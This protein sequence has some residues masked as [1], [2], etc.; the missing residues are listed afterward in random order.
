MVDIFIN[1]CLYPSTADCE[2]LFG[3]T[4]GYYGTVEAQGR[5][6]LHLHCLVWIKNAPSPEKL[7]EKLKSGDQNF[8]TQIISWLESICQGEYSTGTEADIEE[9]IK[10]DTV[11]KSHILSKLPPMPDSNMTDA[12]IADWYQNLCIESDV[13]AYLSNRHSS[14][15]GYGCQTATGQCR[16]RF[17]RTIYDVTTV[18]LSDGAITLK[19]KEEWLNTYN[20]ILTYLMR[21]N[22]DVLSMQSG[23]QLRAIIAYVTDY[24]T[25]SSLKTHALF[26]SIKMILEKSAETRK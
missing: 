20:V 26:D 22:T 18:D 19:H 21:C 12:D 9:L 2:G 16:A 1:T 3:P 5:L 6:S 17:P 13:I 25:K 7:R 14:Q 10:S 23:T 24:I 8:T 4:D 11:S 15:H